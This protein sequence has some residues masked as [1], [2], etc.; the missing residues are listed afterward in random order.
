MIFFD[1]MTPKEE[2]LRALA[3]LEGMD[4]G[5]AK[6][7]YHFF[8]ISACDNSCNNLRFILKNLEENLMIH[9]KQMKERIRRIREYKTGQ[10][11][12][13]LVTEP[14][15]LDF[16]VI[17][18]IIHS[19]ILMNDLSILTIFLVGDKRLQK[20]L[21]D[22]V[23]KEFQS[24]TSLRNAITANGSPYINLLS[25]ELT[26]L[27]EE[28]DWYEEYLRSPRDHII[29]PRKPNE[30]YQTRFT[31]VGDDI[32]TV[33]FP[34]MEKTGDTQQLSQKKTLKP[35]E[36]AL[37]LACFINNYVDLMEKIREGGSQYS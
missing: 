11:L 6:S 16:W 8:G 7:Y 19:R 32:W 1:Y 2:L 37:N 34:I 36:L 29:H 22:G 13:E 9:N 17:D 35:R 3:R 27:I 26:K 23:P 10:S 15:T 31:W 21:E 30:K 12:K 33:E 18:F 4:V 24:F 25:P 5:R 20:S 14:D 28:A